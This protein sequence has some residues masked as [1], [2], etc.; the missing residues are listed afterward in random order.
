MLGLGVM[1]AVSGGGRG[2]AVASPPSAAQQ[3]TGQIESIKV[4]HC[5]W[6]PGTCVGPLV[7][8][9]ARGQ[10]VT[11]AIPSGTSS[12]RGEQHVHIEDLGVGNYVTVR[13]IPLPSESLADNC[14]EVGTSPGE[15]R[16]TLEEA[17]Q[18]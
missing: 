11:L 13:A 16:L 3:Y 6:H 18:E 17:S 1:F 10:E 5:D 12:G 14:G 2:V 9:Q 7:L 15:R 4:D 8:A